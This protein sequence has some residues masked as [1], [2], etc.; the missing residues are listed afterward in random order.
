MNSDMYLTFE[1]KLHYRYYNCKKQG[2]FQQ[3]CGAFSRERG[4]VLTGDRAMV[5]LDP[6]NTTQIV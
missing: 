2:E 3:P 1:K 4:L 5:A 6:D